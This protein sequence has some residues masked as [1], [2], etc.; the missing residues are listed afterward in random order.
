MIDVARKEY[1]PIAAEASMLFFAVSDLGNI[2]PMYQY[3]LSYFIELFSHAIRSSE[4]ADELQQRLSNLKHFFRLMLFN[5][6]SRSLFEKHRLLFSV[7]IALKM[8]K[9]DEELLRFLLT[10]GT[11]VGGKLLDKPQLP[12]LTPKMWAELNRLSGY[13]G[14]DNICFMFNE[15]AAVKLFEVIVQSAK[16]L[17]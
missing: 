1:T 10:G 15:P 8:L 5:N 6:I 2:D 3:S 16:P 13:L 4:K 7:I 11:D 17:E 12:W 9:V 14:Y